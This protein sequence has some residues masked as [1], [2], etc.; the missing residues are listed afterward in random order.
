MHAYRSF[1]T[2]ALRF[3]R[4]TPALAGATPTNSRHFFASAFR[5]ADNPPLERTR[6]KVDEASSKDNSATPGKEHTRDT[7]AKEVDKNPA[8]DPTLHRVDPES[9][10]VESPSEPPKK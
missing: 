3:Q 10:K 1:T 6:E 8:E 7:Y 9:G 4:T 2:T 5:T